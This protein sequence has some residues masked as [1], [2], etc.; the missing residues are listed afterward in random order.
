MGVGEV[1]WVKPRETH[2]GQLLE[3]ERTHQSPGNWKMQIWIQLVC[4]GAWESHS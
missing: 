4:V 1:R 3:L 2:K